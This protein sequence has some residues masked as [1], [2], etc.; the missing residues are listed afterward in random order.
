MTFSNPVEYTVIF[1]NIS[2]ED[3]FSFIGFDACWC[4]CVSSLDIAIA[5]IYSNDFGVFDFSHKKYLHFRIVFFSRL[6]QSG[7]ACCGISIRKMKRKDI[8][9]K[10]S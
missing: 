2:D 10:L 5:M 7:T 3:W 9:L 8:E 6:H 4:D 1:Q